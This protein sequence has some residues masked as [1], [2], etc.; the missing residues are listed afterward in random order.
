MQIINFIKKNKVE[1]LVILLVITLAL[2]LRL[3]RISEFMTYL[4]DEGRDMRIVRD[5]ITEGNLPFIG[6]Q[7][8]VG[9]MYLGPL[10]YY[11][12]APALFLSNL[13]PVGPSIFNAILGSLAVFLTWFITRK[14]FGRFAAIVSA[15]LFA[16]SPVAIIYSRSSWNP[17]PMPFFALLTIYS[18]YQVWQKKSLSWLLLTGFAFASALQMHYLGLL[19]APTIFILWVSA[20]IHYKKDAKFSIFIKYSLFAALIFCLMMSPLLL[21]DIKHQWLNTKAFT[22]LIFGGQGSL[23][24]VALLPRMQNVFSLIINDLFLGRSTFTNPLIIVIP[25][26][27]SLWFI[28]TN[29]KLSQ[30]KILALWIA[31]AVIGLGFYKNEVYIHYLGFIFPAIYIIIGATASY[32]F[33]LEKKFKIVTTL[34]ILLLIFLFIKNS[35]L[36]SEPN[37][38]L[39]RTEEVVDLI[40]SESN[41][42]PFN[43]GLI[44]KNNYDESYRYFFENKNAQMYRGVDKITDQ[45]FVSCEDGDSCKPEGNSQYEIAVFGIAKVVQEWSIDNIKVYKMIHY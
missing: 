39:G 45:L 19:L 16:L 36:R 34:G 5:L 24:S 7:T 26:L 30:V 22:N 41:N 32:F 43:F 15:L 40:I 44:A 37:A 20:F 27:L 18:I 9:N 2:A 23:N 10:Y 8:S 42:Q 13:N 12:I 11:L 1:S 3:F 35:P 21:F 6:A 17:N 29:F 14:W 4:G 38:I 31:M 28:F 25:A 33:F